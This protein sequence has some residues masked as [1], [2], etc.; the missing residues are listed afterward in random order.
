MA[1]GTFLIIDGK[2]YSLQTVGCSISFGVRSLGRFSA[3]YFRG[4]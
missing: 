1:L 4:I 3:I 2:S